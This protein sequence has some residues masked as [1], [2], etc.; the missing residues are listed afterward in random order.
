MKFIERHLQRIIDLCR[1]YRVKSLAVFGSVLTDRFNNQSDIDFLVNFDTTDHENWDYVSNY[2]DLRDALENI[3]GRRVDLIEESALRNKF[4][5]ANV[6][7]TK[8]IIY[9]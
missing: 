9:G 5:I 8:Q 4:F 1:K 2:F 6:N 3:F 7:R